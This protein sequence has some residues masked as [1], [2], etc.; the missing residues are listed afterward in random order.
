MN[1][2][3]FCGIQSHLRESLLFGKA[4]FYRLPPEQE[5]VSSNLAGRTKKSCLHKTP[6]ARG[7]LYRVDILYYWELLNTI[8]HRLWIQKLWIR[9]HY[10]GYRGT[11]GMK[12][13]PTLYEKYD[14]LDKIILEYTELRFCHDY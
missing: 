14:L 4:P 7:F 5:V 6:L 11:V 12:E 2:V 10:Y 9:I 8:I 1:G 13:A 3:R